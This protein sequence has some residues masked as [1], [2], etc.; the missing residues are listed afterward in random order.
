MWQHAVLWIIFREYWSPVICTY[1]DQV[2]FG[3]DGGTLKKRQIVMNVGNRVAVGNCNPVQGMVVSTWPLITGS[4]L[5]GHVQWRG[6][7][8]DERDV[9][10]SCS[11]CS[12]SCFAGIEMFQRKAFGTSWERRTC[13][14]NAVS[15]IVRDESVQETDLGE[16][17]ELRQQ[18]EVRVASILRRNR[19]ARWGVRSED[20]LDAQVSSYVNQLVLF[21]VNQLYKVLM[22]ISTENRLTHLSDNENQ[23]EG[24]VEANVEGEWLFVIGTNGCVVHSHKYEIV[25]WVSEIEVWREGWNWLLILCPRERVCVACHL[26]EKATKIWASNTCHL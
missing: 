3:E 18:I 19:W 23:G 12:N 1:H 2:Q 5:G 22:K 6:Q 13:G 10:P 15:N 11:M 26:H 14:L 16:R 8:L 17:W 9:I 25:W 20:T 4:F 21:L 24:L 7:A